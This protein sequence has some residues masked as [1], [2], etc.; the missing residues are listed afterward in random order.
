MLLSPLRHKKAL[1]I[2]GDSSAEFVETPAALPFTAQEVFDLEGKID[3]SGTLEAEVNYYIR[4]DSEVIFKDA[5]RQASPSKYKDLVQRISYYGGF[6]GEVSQVKVE[7]LESLDQGIR[8]LYHYHRP[9]YLNLQDQVPKKSLP[10]SFSRFPKWEEKEDTLRLYT[11]PGELIHR[12]KIELPSGITIQAPLDIKLDRDYVHYQTSYS[13]QK[14]IITAERKI[15]ILNEEISGNHRSDYA[16]FQKAVDADEAQNMVLHLPPDFVAGKSGASSS[17]A[18]DELM[19]QA[20]IELR[21]N[22]YNGA[23]ADFRKLAERDP[24]RKGIWTQVG[25]V[26]GQLGRY[27]E[28]VDDFQKAIA[29]DPF[30]VTAHTELGSTYFYLKKSSDGVAE[31]KKA[32]EID[33]LSHRAHYLLG[34]EYSS[35]LHDSPNAVLE[36]EKALSTESEQASDEVQI[37]E[38]LSEDYFKLK[39]FDKGLESIKDAVEADP[40]PT[41]WN[42]AAYLLA[43]NDQALDVAQQYADLALKSIYDRLDQLQPGS[44][45]LPDFISMS[46][47]A[48]TWDTLGWIHFKAGRLALAEKYV[49]A[50]WVL[51]QNPTA[52]E[53]LGKIYEK[54]NN[55]PEATRFYA[56]STFPSYLNRPSKPGKSRDRLIKLLGAQR[57]EKMVEDRVNEPSQLRTIHLGNIAP[58]GTKGSYY[59]LLKPDSKTVELQANNGDEHL[60]AQLHKIEGKIADS[61]LFPENAPK[62]L[63]REGFVMCSAY[64]HSCD[65]V[66]ALNDISTSGSQR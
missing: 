18:D 6:A 32:L 51:N 33:P 45:R 29:A 60:T 19:R 9:E 11:S 26:N 27:P 46:Q 17:N 43:E 24:K 37:R 34:W 63:V 40:T 44:I 41:T 25:L 14:N 10:L 5:F 13:A 2:A 54:L 20:E 28:A 8:I 53:H 49:H 39:Q 21:E 47:L 66:F 65:L 38:M 31:L 64:S 62:Q 7:G 52:G 30:D 15:A 4:G 42:N 55:I 48:M 59:F 36:L 56:M 35:I 23:Y 12:C 22:D 3:E 16:A 61:V 57:A 1:V 50:A 58:G